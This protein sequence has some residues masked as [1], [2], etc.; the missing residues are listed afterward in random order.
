MFLKNEKVESL[1]KIRALNDE[2]ALLRKSDCVCGGQQQISQLEAT[3]EE[4]KSKL[5][6]LEMEKLLSEYRLSLRLSLPKIVSIKKIKVEQGSS[7]GEFLDGKLL[8]KGK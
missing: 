8:C 7:S 2:I 4:L 6:K 3:V 1:V 5:N